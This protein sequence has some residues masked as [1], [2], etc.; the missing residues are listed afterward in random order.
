[1]NPEGPSPNGLHKASCQGP[2]QKQSSFLSY[3]RRLTSVLSDCSLSDDFKDVLLLLLFSDA[4]LPAS[5]LL[6]CFQDDFSS[7]KFSLF[8]SSCIVFF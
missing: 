4:L 3:V 8:V 7:S 6:F 5:F 2:S 1:M